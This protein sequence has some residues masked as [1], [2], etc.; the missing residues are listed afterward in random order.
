MPAR[1][2]G[3]Q[4]ALQ[5]IQQYASQPDIAQRL[6]TDQ[7][8]AQR[9]QKYQGQYTFQMQQMQNAEIGRIG[10]NPAQMGETPTQQMP[11]Q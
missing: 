6:Q 11:Q 7:M 5:M 2:T 4:V 8:F 9:L 3:A 10:T 1:P